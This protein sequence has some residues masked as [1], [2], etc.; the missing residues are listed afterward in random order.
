VGGVAEAEGGD[1][2]VIAI[3]P[4]GERRVR[5]A[6]MAHYW[7]N[8][9]GVSGRGGLGAV[10]GAKNLKAVAVRGARKTEIADPAGLKALIEG[11]RE[12]MKK[13]TQALSTFGTPFLSAPSTPSAGS[14]PTT[15]GRRPLPRRAPSAARR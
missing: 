14:A 10:L 3:G 7:K 12:P 5:F 6:A 9:E 15:S 11:T 4:A 1:A 13:G 8:R 2:D